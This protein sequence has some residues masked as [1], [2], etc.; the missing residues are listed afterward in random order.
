MLS[1]SIEQLRQPSD[2]LQEEE[3]EREQCVRHM[4]PPGGVIRKYSHS[5][6]TCSSDGEPLDAHAGVIRVKEEPPDSEDEGRA[7]GAGLR[8][9]EARL[10]QVGGG[11]ATQRV[12]IRAIM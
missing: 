11:D 10:P 7:Q 12:I 5:G 3:E 9:R 4:L 8:D 6:S 2:N 1:Q